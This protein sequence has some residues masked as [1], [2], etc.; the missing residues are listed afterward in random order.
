[1][2][3]GEPS[4]MLPTQNSPYLFS[5]LLPSTTSLHPLPQQITPDIHWLSLLSN[6]IGFEGQTPVMLPASTAS[7]SV[8]CQGE[9][10]R[11]SKDKGK[12]SRTKKTCRPRFAFQTRSAD[13]QVKKNYWYYWLTK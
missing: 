11:G 3:E 7:A 4:A 2:E 10:D 6:P 12:L 8:G 13:D 9:E 1:M 5:P